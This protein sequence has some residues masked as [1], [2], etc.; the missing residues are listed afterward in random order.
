MLVMGTSLK[1]GLDITF[2]KHFYIQGELKE[3]I[4]TCRT[5]EL[6]TVQRIVLQ[7]FFLLS[8]YFFRRK[9]QDLNF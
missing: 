1:A 2:F 8:T 4:S 5:S 3:V 9:I 7:D 6:Q